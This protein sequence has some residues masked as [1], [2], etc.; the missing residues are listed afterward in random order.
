VLENEP[1]MLNDK[2]CVHWGGDIQ[3]N[4]FKTTTAKMSNNEMPDNGSN[5][6]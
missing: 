5:L 4:T 3:K 1:V 2:D 6:F